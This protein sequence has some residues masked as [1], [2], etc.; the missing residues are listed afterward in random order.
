[1]PEPPKDAP[2]NTPARPALKRAFDGV[3]PVTAQWHVLNLRVVD[4]ATALPIPDAQAIVLVN[5]DNQF[6]TFPTNADGR[7]LVSYPTIDDWD[8]HLEVR[9]DGYVP[10]RHQLDASSKRRRDEPLTVRLRPGMPIGG[11]VVDE[12]G[13]PIVGTEVIVT[14]SGYAE[15]R[16]LPKI[17]VGTEIT[18]EVPVTTDAQGRWRCAAV[19]PDA[20]KFN[21]QLV[22]P[23]FVSGSTVSL[24][25]PGLRHPKLPDLKSFS[26]QQVMVKGV[27][28]TGKVVDD[29]GHPIAGADLVDATKGATF[30]DNLRRTTSDAEGLFRFRFSPDDSILLGISA[31]GY[32]CTEWT[33]Q[34]SRTP[35]EIRLARGRTIRGRVLDEQQKPVVNAFICIPNRMARKYKSESIRLWTDAEG[36]FAWD[37]AHESGASLSFSKK[38]YLEL[39]QSLNPSDGETVVAFEPCLTINVKVLDSKTGQAVAPYSLGVQTVDPS[40]GKTQRL[41]GEER[42]DLKDEYTLNLKKS[43][44]AYKVQIKAHGHA[45]FESRIIRNDEKEVNLDVRLD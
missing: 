14:V 8:T 27:E 10:Q 44:P 11:T 1:T 45:D 39:E 40:T 31:K 37:G 17:A 34:T 18:Y 15:P 35:V 22:H 41:P 33:V 38:G 32:A 42:R 20:S 6:R 21:L 12:Q 5:I 36:R 4:D 24:A 13:H 23:D 25:G 16:T 26:D 43:S 9:K 2:D 19:S 3:P 29:E 7:L 28:V 30:L